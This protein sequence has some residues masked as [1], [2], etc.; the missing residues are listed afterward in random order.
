VQ[1]DNPEAYG[2]TSF[3]SK[4]KRVG[5]VDGVRSGFAS[6]LIHLGAYGSP[7]A[8]AKASVCIL[9]EGD[10]GAVAHPLLIS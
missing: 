6:E 5:G 9:S 3:G 10:P 4:P 7:I 1:T 2:G 8:L